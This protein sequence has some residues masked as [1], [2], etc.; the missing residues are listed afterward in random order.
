MTLLDAQPYDAV[1]ARRRKIV[2][3]LSVVSVIVL[4]ALVWFNR[5]WPG[6]RCR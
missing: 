5:N 6:A 1:R 4:A 3:T 2:I